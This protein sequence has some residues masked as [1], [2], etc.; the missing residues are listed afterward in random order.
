MRT[1]YY[2]FLVCSV[3]VLF[4][5]P[6]LAPRLLPPGLGVFVI[7]LFLVLVGIQRLLSF[8]FRC[9]ECDHALVRYP[10]R[11]LGKEISGYQAFPGRTCRSCGADLG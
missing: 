11:M 7:P 1:A 8:Q 10:I 2:I 4:S 6:L 5:F 3:A 9:A